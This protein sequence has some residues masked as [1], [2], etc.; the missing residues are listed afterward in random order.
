MTPE[1]KID[2]RFGLRGPDYHY[3][4]I[5]KAFGA[6]LIFEVTLFCN[7][8]VQCSCEGSNRSDRLANK[9]KGDQSRGL[10]RS[11]SY[12]PKIFL[13]HIL[14][15]IYDYFVTS[16]LKWSVCVAE[17][18]SPVYHASLTVDQGNR[19]EKVQKKAEDGVWVGSGI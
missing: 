14:S 11:Y 16:S 17:Y 4:L 15:A 6:I 8:I 12:Q 1:V 19:L 10:S 7:A 9:D 18:A 2:A 5:F 3:V 13:R